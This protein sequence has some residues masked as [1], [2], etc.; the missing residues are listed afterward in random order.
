MMSVSA[1]SFHA[2]VLTKDGHVFA[3]GRGHV[4]QRRSAT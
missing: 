3:F 2:L 4:A 1:G